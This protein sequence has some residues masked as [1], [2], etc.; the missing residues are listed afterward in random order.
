MRC[1]KKVSD[2][3]SVR[4]YECADK[5]YADALAIA[6]A[7]NASESSKGIVELA[8][9]IDGGVLVSIGGDIATAGDAPSDGWPVRGSSFD[10]D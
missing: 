4:S 9:Q 6:G 8:T 3:L 5:T 10:Y 7:P 2:A 1:R